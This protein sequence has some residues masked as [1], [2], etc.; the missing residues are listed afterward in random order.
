MFRLV[1][2][3]FLVCGHSRGETFIEDISKEKE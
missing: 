3:R 2:V 1:C